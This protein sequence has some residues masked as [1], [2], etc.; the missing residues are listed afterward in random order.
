[1]PWY[2]RVTGGDLPKIDPQKQNTY[3]CDALILGGSVL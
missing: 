3:N 1:M 2:S